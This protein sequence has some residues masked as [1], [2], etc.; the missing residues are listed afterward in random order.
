MTKPDNAP[1]S[2]PYGMLGDDT[3]TTPDKLAK[4]TGDVDW[5]YLKPH[6]ESGVLLYVDPGLDLTTVGET[7]SRDASDKVQ[8]W[9]KTGDLLK[10]SQPH[11]TYWEES[12]AKFTALVVSPFVLIQPLVE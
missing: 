8:E 12:D 4:Y 6:F 3:T 1:E 11:A 9:L 7:F 2:M 10:P 5:S